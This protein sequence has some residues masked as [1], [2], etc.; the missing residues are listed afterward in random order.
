MLRYTNLV[1][2]NCQPVC[3]PLH[4]LATKAT[5]RS[6]AFQVSRGEEEE[7]QRFW[8][9]GTPLASS[10]GYW[11]AREQSRSKTGSDAQPLYNPSSLCCLTSSFTFNC[12]VNLRIEVLKTTHLCSR[13]SKFFYSTDDEERRKSCMRESFVVLVTPLKITVL[14]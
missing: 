2:Q 1:R 5:F 9:D 14:L 4:G 3:D 11:K 6:T 12:A 7:G 8:G 13:R 10:R